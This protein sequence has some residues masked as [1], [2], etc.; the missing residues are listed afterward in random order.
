MVFLRK[1]S[2][3]VTQAARFLGPNRGVRCD[4]RAPS[5][6]QL[7]APALSHLSDAEAGGRRKAHVVGPSTAGTTLARLVFRR[8]LASPS[9]AARRRCR[10]HAARERSSPPPAPPR[11][12]RRPEAVCEHS[13]APARRW[14]RAAARVLASSACENQPTAK[15]LLNLSAHRHHGR[16]GASGEPHAAHPHHSLRSR[17]A[18]A[19][20]VCMCRGAPVRV[21]G[22][23]CGA[24]RLPCTNLVCYPTWYRAAGSPAQQ[25]SGCEGAA[26]ACTVLAKGGSTAN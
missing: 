22:C 3:H 26:R 15:T 11:R 6:T 23:G 9:N 4:R 17:G 25:R 24:R 8:C 18:P 16:V 1:I 10:I 7:A 14:C 19:P 2:D 5:S 21:S 13:P 12:P 20:S